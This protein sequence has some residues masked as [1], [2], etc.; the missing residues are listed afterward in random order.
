MPI[1]VQQT[2]TLLSYTPYPEKLIERAGRVCYKSEDKICEGSA[3]KMIAMLISKGHESVLEHASATVL[4]TTDRGITHELVRHR[5]A[6]FSQESTRYVDYHKLGEMAVIPP[7][8]LT[9][10]QMTIWMHAMTVAEHQY[11]RLRQEGCTPQQARD[12]LPNSLKADIVVTANFREWRTIFKQ[13]LPKSAHPKMRMLMRDV[14]GLLV[15][16]SPTVFKEFLT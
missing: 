5:I 10:D 8:D 16:V 14:L 2:A 7:L 11:H 4:I 3:E 9:P 1:V 12:V 15:C 6:S 13:R